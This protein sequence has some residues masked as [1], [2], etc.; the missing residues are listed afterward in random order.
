M[1]LRKPSTASG[2]IKATHEYAESRGRGV[3]QFA[4]K[5]YYNSAKSLG[6]FI[7]WLIKNDPTVLNKYDKEVA[8]ASSLV[9]ESTDPEEL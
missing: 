1:N 6:D 5:N 4:D 8:D 9:E 3:S 7:S 2:V